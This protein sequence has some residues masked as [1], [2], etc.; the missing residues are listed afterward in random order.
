MEGIL[1]HTHPQ[2]LSLN[3]TSAR[4]KDAALSDAVQELIPEALKR[5]TG[6]SV[7]RFSGRK[8]EVAV[9]LSVPCGEIHERMLDGLPAKSAET[10]DG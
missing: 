8:Y 2:L 10:Q 5:R 4:M 1:L 6:I 7:T 3:V 9:D